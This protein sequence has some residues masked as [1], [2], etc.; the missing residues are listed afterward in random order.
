[1]HDSRRLI[2]TFFFSGTVFLLVCYIVMDY[3]L[4]IVFQQVIL[5]SYLVCLEIFYHSKLNKKS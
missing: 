1:M 2:T 5:S 3:N 4:P